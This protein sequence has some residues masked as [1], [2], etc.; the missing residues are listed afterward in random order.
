M[1]KIFSGSWLF[2]ISH[3]GLIFFK[4]LWI[5]FFCKFCLPPSLFPSNS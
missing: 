1:F 4:H 2:I 5:V 3:I